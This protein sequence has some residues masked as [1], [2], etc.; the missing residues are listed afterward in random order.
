MVCL[1]VFYSTK[2][3]EQHLP[4]ITIEWMVHL[5]VSTPPNKGNHTCLHHHRIAGRRGLQAGPELRP[6]PKRQGG[7]VS[8]LLRCYPVYC[9]VASCRSSCKAVLEG[10]DLLAET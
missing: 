1:T 2:R 6:Q 9:E 7:Q 10:A 8:V 4:Y 3:E 5:T